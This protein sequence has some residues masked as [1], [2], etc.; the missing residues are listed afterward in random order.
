MNNQPNQPNQPNNQQPQQGPQWHGQQPPAYGQPNHLPPTPPYVQRP[1]R[2]N[3]FLRHKILT[4][5]GALVLVGGI[6]SAVASGGGG[7]ATTAATSS[8]SAS[9]EPVGSASTGPSASSSAPSTS[10]A[11]PKKKTPG[12]GTPVRD[13]KFEFTVTKVR[14]GVKSVGDQYLGKQAQGSFVLVSVTVKNIGD[15]SQT[16]FDDN[17]KLTDAD[18]REFSAD[19]EASIYLKNNEL[20]L[21]EINP[22]NTATGTI[23]YDMPAGA[24]PASLELHDSAFSGGV[25]VSLR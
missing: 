16:M 15:R 10:S 21:K 18:G 12:I 5:L 22:G 24:V 4:G 7:S 8:N 17:Q 20:W 9:S 14:Q 3:W 11:A 25:T 1:Q 2:K 19:S 13:G 23:V 6:G